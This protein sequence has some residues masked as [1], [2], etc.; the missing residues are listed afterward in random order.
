MTVIVLVVVAGC[1]YVYL[2]REEVMK[3]LEP[4]LVALLQTQYVSENATDLGSL[5]INF[6]NMFVSSEYG[7]D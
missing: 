1:V 2:K 5:A 3:Q 4:E 6:L 7:V